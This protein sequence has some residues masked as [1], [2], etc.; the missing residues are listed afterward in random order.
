MRVMQ[1][2]WLL[3]QLGVLVLVIIA[4]PAMYD[5]YR[6]TC[7]ELVCDGLPQLNAG[8]TAWLQRLG[9]AIDDYALVMVTVEWLYVLLWACLGAV[10]I[11]KRPHE[12][13]ALL[14]ACLSIAFGS[15]LFVGA[16]DRSQTDVDLVASAFRLVSY[17]TFPL[18][19]ALFPDGR[20]VPHWTRW[21]ALGGVTYASLEVLTPE[22]LGWLRDAVTMPL[23]LGVYVSLMAAQVIRYRRVSTV[24]QRQQSKWLLY[25][26]GLFIFNIVV[27]MV[28]FVSGLFD[29]YQ[30]A[31][32]LT[33]YSSSMLAVV[34]IGF[35]V[36]RHRL[37]DI[38]IIINRTIVYGGLTASV[39]A[40][41]ALIV[42]GL[43]ALL[44][45]QSVAISFLAAGALAIVFQPL[46][47][48]LQRGVNRLLYGERD[49]PYA[50]LARLGQRLEASIAPD[51]VLPTIVETVSNALKLPYVAITLE[52]GTSATV[53]AA[54]GARPGADPDIV[55]L[56]YH[57][58]PVGQ[59]LVAPRTGEANISTADRQLL[60]DL[61]R[62]AGAAAHTVRLNAALQHSLEQLVTAREEERR[63]LRRDLHDG[64][65]PALASQALTIDTARLLLERDPP[66]A[67]ALLQEAKTQSQ[68]AVQE[69]RRVVHALRPPALDDLGLAGALRELANQYTGVGVVITV[70]APALLPPLPA[71]VEVAAYRIAQE[72]LTNVV[73]H[74]DARRCD[75]TLAIDTR[76][77]LSIRDDGRGV[78]ADRRA[79]VGLASM[80][81]RAHELGGTCAVTSGAGGGTEIVVYLPLLEQER[82]WT[83]STS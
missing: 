31:V 56:A 73:R 79:G 25:A 76:L 3:L 11:W 43:G 60:H 55:P 4:T 28:A 34:A 21:V 27:A 30:I 29:P 77:L 78:P 48:R 26:V 22:P 50:V 32:V 6:T 83:A 39:V 12:P 68:H 64:L 20:W 10:L 69:I 46:R 49:E 51:T 71:A 9:V 63:R 1:V 44:R 24:V 82:P 52:P 61:A 75:V 62:Q 47:A 23:A 80:R 42:G 45:T 35:A 72:A 65:G 58:E 2:G 5:E 19:G 59:L 7:P 18:I 74:A 57:G 38:D 81:E 36:L 53:A 70:S 13:M 40:I 66:A 8:S 16:L 33:C 37:F 41:Y 15:N 17:A 67:A 54:Y 14:I